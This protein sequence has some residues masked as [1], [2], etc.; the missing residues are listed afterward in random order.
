MAHRSRP[1]PSATP[2]GTDRRTQRGDQPAR[3]ATPAYP[4]RQPAR[5][6]PLR[7]STTARRWIQAKRTE[8]NRGCGRS[9]REA[10]GRPRL[11][12]WSLSSSPACALD[13]RSPVDVT[14]WLL[15]TTVSTELLAAA[16]FGPEDEVLRQ[17]DTVS[18]TPG[19]PRH[20]DRRSRHKVRV[21]KTRLR[22]VSGWAS[23]HRPSTIARHRRLRRAAEVRNPAC[24]SPQR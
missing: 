23:C 2:T 14:P 15:A 21:E 11:R 24:G 5:P 20:A 22:S 8:P 17:D 7:T 13:T 16:E 9:L 19:T 3:P 10:I 1:D 18:T 6:T 4:P 12:G